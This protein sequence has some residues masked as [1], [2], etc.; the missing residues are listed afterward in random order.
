MISRNPVSTKPL[1]SGGTSR[2][3]VRRGGV[4]RLRLLSRRYPRGKAETAELF[5]GTTLIEP[6]LVPVA[7]WRPELTDRPMAVAEAESAWC[8]RESAAS[9][10]PASGSDQL[11]VKADRTN[12]SRFTASTNAEYSCWSNRSRAVPAVGAYSGAARN[13]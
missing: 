3:A 10:E 6:G 11:T 8:W 9:P 4:S 1:V 2:S 5:R 12:S 7:T 13:S